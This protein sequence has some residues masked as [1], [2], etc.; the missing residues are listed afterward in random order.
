MKVTCPKCDG[1]IEVQ[2]NSF[3][4]FQ[5][6]TSELPN[7]VAKCELIEDGSID[8]TPDGVFSCP[9]LNEAVYAAAFP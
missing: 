4:P 8:A 9:I 5:W 3:H 7:I 6:G 1:E 2:V